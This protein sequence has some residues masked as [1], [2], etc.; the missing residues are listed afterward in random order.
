MPRRK[1]GLVPQLAWDFINLFVLFYE[2]RGWLPLLSFMH[3]SPQSW[4]ESLPRLTLSQSSSLPA[5]TSTSN[6][7]P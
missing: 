4:G 5:R 1:L 3:L 7:L 6:F 2:P